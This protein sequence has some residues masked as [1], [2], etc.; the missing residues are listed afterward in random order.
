LN[1]SI[2]VV[3][4]VYGFNGLYFDGIL[5]LGYQ[6]ITRGFGSIVSALKAAG[7]INNAI[8]SLYYN[9]DLY[10]PG[11]NSVVTFGD[12]NPKFYSNTTAYP[13]ITDTQVV[14]TYSYWQLQSP[15]ILYNDTLLS[16]E[17]VV[18]IDSGEDWIIVGQPSYFALTLNLQNQNFTVES[19]TFIN[20]NCT[21]TTAYPSI[22]ISIN[23]TY[24]EIPSFRYIVAYPGRENTCYTKLLKSNDE[25]WYIGA[26]IL[27]QYYTSFNTDDLSI[28]FTLS[29][30]S[31]HTSPYPPYPPPSPPPP[32]IDDDGLA[33]WEIALIVIFT[34][35]G[36]ALIG[37]IV[38]FF[39]KRRRKIALSDYGDPLREVSLP[40][41]N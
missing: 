3:D 13:T 8:Y 29:V 12:P 6:S 27:R 11:N 19:F 39:I 22:W 31:N 33:G 25:N 5:G 28:S 26:P 32:I 40:A 16:K 38:V 9:D 15:Y 20:T 2:V 24:I 41:Q 1:Y 30:N 23:N 4:Q 10:N 21:N 7:L 36:V 34:V 35:L 18:V 17:T 37:F 14:G